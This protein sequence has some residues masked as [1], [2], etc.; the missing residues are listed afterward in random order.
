VSE[1]LVIREATPGDARSIARLHA[2]SWR[3]AYRGIYPD[4]YLDGEVFAERQ[5]HWTAFLADLDRAR[6]LVL[7][8]EEDG[9]AIGFA[10]LKRG[11][12]APLLDNLHVLPQRKGRRFGSR[13]LAAAAAWL[14]EREPGAPLEL[15]VLAEN[16]PARGFYASLGGAETG[17]G[18]APTPGGGT[19]EEVRI[20][21]ERASDLIRT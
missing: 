19:A 7:V 2:L 4:A 14:V 21:W 10:C 20:R 17:C 3:S 11:K 18:A 13:L 12:G 5:A 1:E 15:E 8:A 16:R 9:R 6:N